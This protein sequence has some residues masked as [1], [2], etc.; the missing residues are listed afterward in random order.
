MPE[1]TGNETPVSPTAPK[2]RNERTE[3]KFF[4]DVEKVITE[5]ERLGAAYDPPNENAKLPNLK[6]KRDAALAA[7]AAN[8]A[9][10]AAEEQTR[11]TRENL[12]KSLNGDI[13]SLTQYAKSAG[14]AE[15]E[16]AALESIARDIKGGRAKP[17]DPNGGAQHIS[18]A[19]L[20][21]ASRA[22]NYAEFI[23]QYDALGIV[24]KE[25]KYKTAT[26]RAKQTALAQ[27]NNAVIAAESNSSTTGATL[28][29]LKYLD[30]DS[31]MNACI[32]AKG[33]IKSKYGTKGQPYLSISKTRLEMPTRLRNRK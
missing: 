15:N 26:H 20:S 19:N 2:K 12:F 3:A 30:N 14:K 28:D 21:F 1:T 32:S 17:V 16:I 8:Q 9:S 31:L 25:E 4:E 11:N 7:R 13:T 18:T 6:A 24:T 29:N 27:S 23:E 22:D 10:E 5:A 33:Y